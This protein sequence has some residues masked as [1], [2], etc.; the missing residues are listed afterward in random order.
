MPAKTSLK[1]AF[2]SIIVQSNLNES[3]RLSQIENAV[4]VSTGSAL[5]VYKVAGRFH[6]GQD[7]VVQVKDVK[8]CGGFRV[9]A[10]NKLKTAVLLLSHL[11]VKALAYQSSS[12]IRALLAIQT[13]C[14][15]LPRVPYKSC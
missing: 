8:D 3:R 2:P 6:G 10:S 4:C 12:I 11:S 13:D 15:S 1:Q 5:G 7:H 14:C 9:K